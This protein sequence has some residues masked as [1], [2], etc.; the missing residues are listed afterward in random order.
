MKRYRVGDKENRFS[1]YNHVWGKEGQLY[2]SYAHKILDIMKYKPTIVESI[3]DRY[4]GNDYSYNYRKEFVTKEIYSLKQKVVFCMDWVYAAEDGEKILKAIYTMSHT[5]LKKF[6]R[7]P[8]KNTNELIFDLVMHP[9]DITSMLYPYHG[10]GTL[11]IEREGSIKD[12]VLESCP[13]DSIVVPPGSVPLTKLEHPELGNPSVPKILRGPR[14]YL[15]MYLRPF[16]KDVGDR[17]D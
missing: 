9:D 17:N 5:T 7:G 1:E 10:I 4:C 8:Y 3:D 12:R 2:A 6:R 11:T 16:I 14:T 13:I 15:F